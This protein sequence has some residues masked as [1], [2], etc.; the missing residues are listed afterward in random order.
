MTRWFERLLA[1]ALKSGADF[2]EIFIVNEKAAV[3][4]ST[5]PA[6]VG[7]SYDSGSDLTKGL[8]EARKGGNAYS[9]LIPI[10]LH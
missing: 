3:I 5:S 6:H 10:H 7:K 1:A 2:S 9:D 8:E 4:Y